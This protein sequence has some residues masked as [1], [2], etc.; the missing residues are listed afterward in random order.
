MIESLR[1]KVVIE[2]PEFLFDAKEIGNRIRNRRKE[3]GLSADDVAE[4]C[5]I[6]RSTYYRIEKGEGKTMSFSNLNAIIQFLNMDASIV[7]DTEK[8]PADVSDELT[9]I[10]NNLDEREKRLLKRI[11]QLPPEQRMSLEVLLQGTTQ[12]AQAGQG[13]S[14]EDGG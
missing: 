8:E 10:I 6:K 5:H 2:M 4:K 11:H 9:E 7:A 14:R 1:K 12:S 3:L 13:Q